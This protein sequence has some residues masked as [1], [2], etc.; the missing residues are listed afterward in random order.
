MNAAFSAPKL[1]LLSVFVSVCTLSATEKKFVILTA[2]YN[3]IKN[4]IWNLDSIFGQTYRNWELVYID[5]MSNDGTTEAVQAY[6]KQKG[7]EDKVKF[8]ANTEKCYCLKNYY[9]E[10]HLIANDSIIVNLDGDDAFQDNHVLE[11]LN[12]VY[13]NPHVW[14]TFGDFT[15]KPPQPKIIKLRPFPKK[16][17]KKNNFRN[18]RW[19]GRSTKNLLCWS[20]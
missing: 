20:F 12:G 8:V 7:F 3:N 1:L 15:H 2:S 9:R 4:Y 18:Y 6:I 17:V 16:I 19:N 5:D 10:I 14:C 13:S 11:Y